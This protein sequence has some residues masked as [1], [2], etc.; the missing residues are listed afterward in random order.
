[1]SMKYISREPLLPRD[2]LTT[3][4][5]LT[6][7]GDIVTFESDLIALIDFDRVE[8]HIEGDSSAPLAHWIDA[9]VE[10]VHF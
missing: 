5:S 2:Y 8:L 7:S 3:F 4:K 9:F 10:V 6:Y 1:M